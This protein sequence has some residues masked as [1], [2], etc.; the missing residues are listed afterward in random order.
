MITNF[1]LL[2]IALILTVG[3][4]L[5]ILGSFLLIP[6][7]RQKVVLAAGNTLNS[8]DLGYFSNIL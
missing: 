6:S 1:S 2:Q 3:S 4:V 8:R 5:S 7:Q